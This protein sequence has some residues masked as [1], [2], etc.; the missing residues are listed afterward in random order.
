MGA[1]TRRDHGGGRRAA[2]TVS[3]AAHA[4]VV[5][6]VVWRLGTAPQAAEAPVMNVQL[7]SLPQRAPREAPR[8]APRDAPPRLAVAPPTPP[9]DVREANPAPE[10]AP[11]IQPGVVQALRGL[12]G[13]EHA[14]LVGL[15]AE[16]RERCRDRQTA[17]AAASRGQPPQRLAL[18]QRG[19]YAVNPELYINR[20]PTKGCKPRASRDVGP[21]GKE[22][23]KATVNCAV[24]F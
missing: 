21:F 8:T 12:L 7:A 15:S 5:G 16:E 13:C 23:A 6:L 19:D 14:R 18:D 24:P 22:G 10:I 11:G 4:V 3:L 17:E 1:K 2:V 20:L 9:P